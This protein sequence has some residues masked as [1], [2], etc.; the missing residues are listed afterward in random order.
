VAMSETQQEFVKIITWNVNGI[1][2]LYKDAVAMKQGLDSL[3]GD[4]ICLQE[5]RITRMLCELMEYNWT[6]FIMGLKLVV[7]RMFQHIRVLVTKD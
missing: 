6:M 7:L 4:I 3:D 5:T 2:S 1:R